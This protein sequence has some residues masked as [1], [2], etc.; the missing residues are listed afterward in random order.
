MD[1]PALAA[2]SALP[3][4][5]L[6]AAR[7]ATRAQFFALGFLSG[8]WGAHVP[9]AQAHYQLSAGE[10][11][12]ALLSAA[13]GA[14]LCLSRAGQLVHAWGPRKVVGAGG[15]MVCL[16]FAGLLLPQ[17]FAA[18]LVMM[19]VFGATSALVDVSINAEGSLLEKAS[20]RKVMSGFHGMWSA[21]GMSGAA[22]SG[23]LLKAGM[24]PAAQ[25]ALVAALALTV[26]TVAQRHMLRP[27]DWAIGDHDD[28]PVAFRRP[29]GLLLLLGVLGISGLLAEGAIYDWSVL[30]MQQTLGQPQAYA[31]LA[32]ACFAG[33]MAVNRFA[34]DWLRARFD[35]PTLMMAS[36]AMGALA[37]AVALLV[38]QPLVALVC[39]VLV[40]AGLANLVPVIFMAASHVPGVPAAAGIATVSALGYVGFV[41]GPPLIGLVTQATSLTGGLWVVVVALVLQAV[42]AR[43]L[44]R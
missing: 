34:G 43:W 14:V 15:L 36:A 37:M 38:Q 12:A 42:G 8:A 44:P 13:L 29:R 9:S 40:G 28:A 25:L 7:M 5:R 16:T 30:W 21:G 22:L 33:S 11:S 31:A 2:A 35:A 19:L 18:L 27:A 6:S 17:N 1:S 26:G 41:A 32:Y 10:L 39:L 23:L 20:Q 24:P 3:A 4:H